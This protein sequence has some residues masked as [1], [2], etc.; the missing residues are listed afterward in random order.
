MV[1]QFVEDLCENESLSS[2]FLKL[3]SGSNTLNDLNEGNL[4][5]EEQQKFIESVVIPFA[6]QHGYEF[7]MKDIAAEQS[8]ISDF[9]RQK[10]ILHSLSD[11]DLEAISGGANIKKIAGILMATQLIGMSASSVHAFS[12]QDNDNVDPYSISVSSSSNLSTSAQVGILVGSVLATAGITYGVTKLVSKIKTPSGKCGKSIKWQLENDNTLIISGK[13]KMNDFFYSDT[14]KSWN[15][16]APWEKYKSQIKNVVI[17]DGVTSIGNRAFCDCKSLESV[18]LP[19]SVTEI[20]YWAFEKCT[21]LKKINIPDSVTNITFFAFSGCDS[22]TQSVGENLAWKFDG[23]NTLTISGQGKMSNFLNS[24][25]VGC[26]TTPWGKYKS[27][28]KNV[29][30]EDGVTSIGNYAFCD[31]KSL[32]SVSLPNSVTEIGEGVF[33]GCENL[34]KI[35][36]PNSVAKIGAFAFAGC[37]LSKGLHI[38]NSVTEIGKLAFSGC[39]WSWWDTTLQISNKELFEKVKSDRAYFGLNGGPNVVYQP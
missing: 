3:L 13:G 1:K 16:E 15:K 29:V 35:N 22:L 21:A 30:I 31:Y 10:Q 14:Y 32:E 37:E 6:K 20:G 11:D 7:S 28:I 39:Y 36:I 5:T 12:P 17:E 24:F 38:P 9:I 8:E 25:V 19:N 2:E 23:K 26:V 33:D 4:S 27:Q 18:S 34:T